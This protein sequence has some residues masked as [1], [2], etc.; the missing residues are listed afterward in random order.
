MAHTNACVAEPITLRLLH[1]RAA[2]WEAASAAVLYGG[3]MTRWPADGKPE[4]IRD[5]ALVEFAAHGVEATSISTVAA[6]ASVSIGLIQHH[7]GSKGGLVDAVDRHVIEL[8]RAALLN[9]PEPATDGDLVVQLV[10]L[11]TQH[12]A[13]A[14]Y[15]GR[16]LVDHT[17][18]GARLFDAAVEMETDRRRWL[19]DTGQA[20]T[21]RDSPWEAMNTLALVVGAVVL[22][23][24]V[25]RHLPAPLLS[26]D[27]L[28]RWRSSVN[29]MTGTV[30]AAVD[31]MNER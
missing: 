15:A 3:G 6:R 25:D 23:T 27:E 4:K 24:H 19:S 1:W 29:T 26:P 8:L 14:E 22:R 13:V 28:A 17:P 11:L 21:D 16:S 20:G 12:S 31:V 10:T 7:F 5:A 9:A 30:S 18:F 2:G